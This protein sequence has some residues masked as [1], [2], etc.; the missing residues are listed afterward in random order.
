M[1]DEVPEKHTQKT[2]RE[3]KA[4]PES[5]RTTVASGADPGTTAR[6]IRCEVPVVQLLTLFLMAILTKALLTLVRGNFMTFTF[7]SARHIAN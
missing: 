3:H 7:F 4:F 5:F 1:R 2:F 6:G